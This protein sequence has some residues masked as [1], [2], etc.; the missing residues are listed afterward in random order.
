[1]EKNHE[2]Y[3]CFAYDEKSKECTALE[4]VPTENRCKTCK[5]YKYKY[6]RDGSLRKDEIDKEI[7]YYVPFLENRLQL[8]KKKNKEEKTKNKED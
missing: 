8:K 6:L 5:F 7:E 1:M 4:V 3:N 2:K